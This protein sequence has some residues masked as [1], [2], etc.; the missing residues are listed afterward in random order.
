ME[1]KA[2]AKRNGKTPLSYPITSNS[3]DVLLE[4]VVN[5]AARRKD[6]QTSVYI[7]QEESKEVEVL[8]YFR[9][10]QGEKLLFALEGTRCQG[11][12]AKEMHQHWLS[13]H[14]DLEEHSKPLNSSTDFCVWQRDEQVC[15]FND[16]VFFTGTIVENM[17]GWEQAILIEF[18]NE[19]N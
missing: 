13:Q 7:H 10:Y 11:Q 1:F 4:E 2:C 18:L 16:T 19:S 14:A 9:I 6:K 15:L 5:D 12:A 8:A 17:D 3:I